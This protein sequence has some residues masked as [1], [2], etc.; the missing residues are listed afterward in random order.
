VFFCYAGWTE[1]DAVLQKQLDDNFN[2]NITKFEANIRGTQYE[3]DLT[4][5]SNWKQ[6]NKSNR[7]KNRRIQREVPSN[8]QNLATKSRP[9]QV[10]SFSLNKSPYS[11]ASHKSAAHTISAYKRKIKAV[12]EQKIEGLNLCVGDAAVIVFILFVVYMLRKMPIIA[13]AMALI[14]YIMS[15]QFKR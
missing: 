9:P 15:Q 5:A 14:I 10:N 13:A 11:T 2:A 3:I 12:M 4:I 8:I 7:K 6:I 1:Y